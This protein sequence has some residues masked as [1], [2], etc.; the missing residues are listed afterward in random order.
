MKQHIYPISP[1]NFTGEVI[2]YLETYYNEN[3]VPKFMRDSKKIWFQGNY[4]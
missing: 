4:C 3:K 2:K 1:V